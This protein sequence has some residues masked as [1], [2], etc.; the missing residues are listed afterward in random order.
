MFQV[1]KNECDVKAAAA[2]VGLIPNLNMAHIGWL[3]IWLAFIANSALAQATDND[4]YFPLLMPKVHPTLVETYL[5]TPVRLND[6]QTHFVIGFK[7]NATMH[8]AHHMLIYGCE[9][10]GSD[11]DVYN[12]GEMAVKQPGKKPFSL[13]LPYQT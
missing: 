10:P 9:E 3:S 8:T 6:V 5:C 7:P 4:D 12:C 2:A 13:L 1:P 11:E